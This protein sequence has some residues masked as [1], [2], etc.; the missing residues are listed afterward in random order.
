MIPRLGDAPG[1]PFPP[2]EDALAE[3][4]GLLAWGGDLSP[5]RLL[6][7]YRQG[8]FPWY[9]AGDP[10]LWWCPAERCVIPTDAVHV[11]RR[12]GRILRQDR[13]R[14]TADRA[15]DAVVEGC[16]SARRSTWIVPEMAAAYR[17]LHTLG[18]AHSI[19]AWQD[20]ELVGGLYGVALGRMFFGESMYSARSEASKVV[21]ARLCAV[22]DRWGFPWLD[23][24]VPSPHLYRMGAVTVPREAFLDRITALA[25][26]AGRIGAWTHDFDVTLS[27]LR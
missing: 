26:D 25:S 10:L 5:E 4:D 20:D 14:V 8:I 9:S 16:A 12:L 6:R 24:Q 13:F 27:R 15:F 22:L 21:L 1:A 2:A 3:P 19:E 11:S 18:H 17:R 7:A 23:G